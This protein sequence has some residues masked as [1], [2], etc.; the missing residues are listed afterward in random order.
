MGL[1][2]RGDYRGGATDSGKR[3]EAES[4]PRRRTS[5]S[6][7]A[8]ESR[9]R[10]AD[11]AAN[12]RSGQTLVHSFAGSDRLHA[13]PGKLQA[14]ASSMRNLGTVLMLARG[15]SR[16]GRPRLNGLL[17]ENAQRGV[18]RRNVRPP[19]EQ[20][21]AIFAVLLT[22]S[23]QPLSQTAVH[24]PAAADGGRGHEADSLAQACRKPTGCR[25][26]FMRHTGGSMLSSDGLSSRCTITRTYPGLFMNALNP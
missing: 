3:G 4:I 5:A 1:K 17:V 26:S 8:D 22:S 15:V 2:Q 20:H 19:F 16:R 10:G 18:P 23:S 14:D 6:T 13:A 7:A 11:P 24:H 12:P 21:D 9:V 25:A